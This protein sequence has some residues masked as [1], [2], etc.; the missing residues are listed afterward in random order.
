MWKNIYSVLRLI[1]KYL[2]YVYIYLRDLKNFSFFV[3]DWL[4]LFF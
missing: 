1:E 3:T 2:T 4:V